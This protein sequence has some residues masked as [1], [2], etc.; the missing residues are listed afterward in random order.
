MA[1]LGFSLAIPNNIAGL[2]SSWANLNVFALSFVLIAL[3]WWWH[4]KLFLTY[5]HMNSA[6]IVMNFVLLGSLVYCIYFQ[7]VTVHFAATGIHSALPLRLWLAFMALNFA[8][9]AGM[10]AIGI[11]EGRH[12]LDNR[13]MR[14]GVGLTYETTLSCLGLAVVGAIIP[15]HQTGAVVII[16]IV[17][18][19]ASFRNTVASR[20][21]RLLHPAH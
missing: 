12:E 15:N 21:T 6:T 9:L 17:V 16:L 13:A 7:Q 20:L 19:F 10:Y 4:H 5:F 3:I 11:W 8:L 2:A 14:W 1:E 18:L